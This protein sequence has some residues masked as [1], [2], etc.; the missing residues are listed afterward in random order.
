MD[1]ANIYAMYVTGMMV[2]FAISVLVVA[3]GFR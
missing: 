1:N 3:G 2:I